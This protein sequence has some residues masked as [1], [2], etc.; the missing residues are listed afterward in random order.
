MILPHKGCTVRA[1]V[2]RWHGGCDDEH[3]PASCP[4]GT[5]MLVK[6]IMTRRVECVGPDTTLQDAA[7]KMRELNVGP[8]PVCGID[9]KLAGMLTDRDITVRATAEGKDPTRTPV[10]EVMTPEV[11]YV[12]EDQD[13]K[14]AAD[15]MSVHQIRRVLVMNRD[16]R[17][18]GIV[19]M[20]DLAVDAGK[21]ARPG[22]TLRQ[23]SEPAEPN[24]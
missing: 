21:E 9:D 16:E 17:L 3:V 1:I 5:I 2:W 22:E 8:L 18:V 7:R 4:G 19:S 11:V 13:A 6:D 12:F 20:A 23:V 10:R 15:T 24:R 14:D